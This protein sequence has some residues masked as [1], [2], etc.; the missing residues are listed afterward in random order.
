MDKKTFV[1]PDVQIVMFQSR[2]VISTSPT[3]SGSSSGGVL[4]PIDPD[5]GK[6]DLRVDKELQID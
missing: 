2:D 1:K 3:N 6:Y 5:I 4:L